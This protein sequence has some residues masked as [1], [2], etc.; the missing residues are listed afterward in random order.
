M[1]AGRRWAIVALGVLILLASP[2]LLRAI[3]VPDTDESARALLA[4]IRDS[5]DQSFSGLVE[6]QGAVAL[7]DNDA[8]SGL[9]SLLG[10][11]QRVRVWW[12]DPATWRT[13]TL[14][15]SGETDLVHR[16]EL[17]VRWVYESKTAT[18]VRDAPARLPVTSDLLPHELARRVLSG[19][20]DRELSRLPARRVAGRDALGLRLVPSLEQAV[21]GRVDVWA[22]RRTGLPLRVEVYDRAGSTPVLSSEVVELTFGRPDRAA[23][24]FRPPEDADLLFDDI[25][26]VAAA[27]DRFS[28]RVP[29]ATLAGL[30]SR[31]TGPDSRTI[32]RGMGDRRF[33]RR[34]V[35][36]YGRGPTVLLAIPL[37][38][39]GAERVRKDLASAPNVLDLDSGLLAGAPPVQLLLA[40]PER[41]G[42]SW[43]LAGT[44]T[45]ATLTAAAAQLAGTPSD[46]RTVR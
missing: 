12:Q 11:D 45:P 13:A 6:T 5:R 39:R 34:S 29:P 33:Q 24:E 1:T 15:A 32:R 23:L 3:P 4:R 18:L 26:D 43:L 19:A 20:R 44:V 28:N 41:D 10:Q 25:V 9:T 46:P 14:R 37:W 35:G 31:R 38:D 22:D 42:T 8:L 36:V 27:A 17:M 40:E 21:L 16:G 7:P 2:F 30:A